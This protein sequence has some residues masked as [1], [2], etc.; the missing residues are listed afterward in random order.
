MKL[1]VINLPYDELAGF[2]SAPL[3]QFCDT[4]MVTAWVDH[5]FQHGGEPHLA[6]IVA[7]DDRSERKRARSASRRERDPRQELP[8]QARPAYDRLREWRS[9]RARQDGVPIYVVFNN[10]ELAAIAV[11][12]PDDREALKAIEG[13]GKGKADKYADDVFLV[14]GS[15][16]EPDHEETPGAPDG[17]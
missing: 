13:I 12:A 1:T 5:F 3:D 17:P 7:Y 16:A 14:L 8:P 2:D 6:V 10:R 11:A 4:H 9:L 15:L